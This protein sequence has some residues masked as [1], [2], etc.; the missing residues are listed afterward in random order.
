M[1]P[2]SISPFISGRA[3][4][5]A[6][7]PHER[8]SPRCR[9]FLDCGQERAGLGSPRGLLAERSGHQ[10]EGPGRVRRLPPGRR[11]DRHHQAGEP[12]V[13]PVRLTGCSFIYL[14]GE[15]VVYLSNM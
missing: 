11:A 3:V 6:G 12:E 7:W 14:P 1:F 8:Q 10:E 4:P 9:Q 13:S 5:P 15:I 2:C